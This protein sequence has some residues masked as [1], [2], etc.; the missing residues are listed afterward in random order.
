LG[1]GDADELSDIDIWVVVADAHIQ[2]VVEQRQQFVAQSSQ[3]LFFVEAPQNAPQDGGYL[4]A[5]YNGPTGPHQ[6]DW[7]WQSQSLAYIP[8][9]TTILFE[10]TGLPQDDRPIEFPKREPVQEIVENPF[11][12][13]SFFWAMLLITAKCVVRQS[14]TEEMS[15]LPYVLHPLHKAQRLLDQEPTAYQAMHTTRQEK[16]AVLRRL[17]D[18]MCVLMPQVAARGN[19]VPDKAPTAVYKFLDLVEEVLA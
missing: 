9:E 2:D 4:M 5:Y 18:E 13:I 8:A 15:L 7:Y 11:H 3:P 12:F 6:V 17:A 16:L 19:A 1:R 14:P 10:H